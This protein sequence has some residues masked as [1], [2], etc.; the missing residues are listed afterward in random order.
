MSEVTLVIDGEEVKAEEGTTILEVARKQDID[1]PTLC[2]HSA[3]SPYGACRVC[4]VEIT[5]SRGRKRIVSSCTYP[6]EEGL[7]V[8][9]K[10]ERVIKARKIVLEL[11][12]ARAPDAEKIQ[13]LAREY[14]IEAPRFKLEEERC[15]LCGLCTRICEERMGVSAIN[16]VG[17]GVEREVKTPFQIT[18]DPEF[19]PCM[20][21]GAC[22]FVCPTGAIDLRKQTK[23]E[24]IPIPAEF[25]LGL[26]S[27]G[28][29]YIPFP[30]AV[31]NVPVIDAEKCVH[32][33]DGAGECGICRD[34]CGAKAIDFE[35]EEEII[36][37][38]VGTIIVATGYDT[39][40]PS[41][42]SEYGY[43]KYDNVITGLEFERLCS[44]SGPTGGKILL[45]NGKEPKKVVFISC[46]GS[47]D[48]E[49]NAYC[50]R[51]CCMYTAKHA[52]LVCE[53][54]PDAEVTIL[55][56]DVRAFGK[57]YEEFYERV[58]EE[59]A[60]YLRREL[61]DPIEIV[62]E[63]GKLYVKAHPH[64]PLEADLVVLATATIPREDAGEIGRLFKISR[65]ADGF[66]AEAHPKLRPVDTATD[67][68]FL[69]GACQGPKDIPDTV[70]QASGAASR[71]CTLLSTGKLKTEAITSEVNETICRGCGFC[72][73][74][75]PYG[76][77][78]LK[79]I[80]RFG[81]TVEVASVND[82]LCKGC[83]AC[84]GAC[85]SGAIQQRMFKDEQILEAIAAL[86]GV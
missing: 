23:K 58:K 57:G 73:E 30:Y 9:T 11:L 77:I 2:Y 43:G 14:G 76:A 45:K 20:A 71:A 69:A 21:C 54:I 41:L 18:S 65:S 24:P 46:V 66:F 59:G 7:V 74:V 79:E 40:D 85:L 6:V 49:G 3:L 60:R 31:P 29:I 42:K 32:F 78:E 48:K 62:E 50:S 83:G 82:A 64:P 81:Y 19:D 25:D 1:I 39:F 84:A 15:I 86:G 72:V 53:K 4:V 52:H 35:Q 16:F 44:A 55:Y 13:E 27:R 36:E 33:L 67:G 8:D 10:S 34:L 26:K 17:R 38:N 5:D 51:V 61:E 56:T 22:E 47:R 37:L 12:L 80:N 70:A 63:N 28:C 68:I 75:C